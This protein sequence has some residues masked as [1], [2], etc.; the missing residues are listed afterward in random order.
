[1]KCLDCCRAITYPNE[2]V[3]LAF[4]ISVA[5]TEPNFFRTISAYSMMPEIEMSHNPTALLG[6]SNIT[7][8][9]AVVPTSLTSGYF[10]RASTPNSDDPTNIC[11]RDASISDFEAV[12]A[13]IE[14]N[15]DTAASD[16]LLLLRI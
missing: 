10:A 11:V 5:P 6:I 13:N 15:P 8:Y 14:S 1:M 16:C 12:P 9:A 4:A 7:T 2:Q 3:V